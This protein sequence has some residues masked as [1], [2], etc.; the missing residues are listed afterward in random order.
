M[1]NV[2]LSINKKSK[3]QQGYIETTN[4]V[5]GKDNKMET[6]ISSLNRFKKFLHKLKKIYFKNEN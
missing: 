2:R 3:S 6:S 5:V 1:N 4:Y